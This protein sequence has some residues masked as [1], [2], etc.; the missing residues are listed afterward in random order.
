MLPLHSRGLKGL[1]TTKAGAGKFQ[2]C[3]RGRTSETK[4][5]LSHRDTLSRNCNIV[6][7]GSADLRFV[8]V[9]ME[10]FVYKADG[11]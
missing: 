6:G 1:G 8:D 7:L 11:R 5:D 9:W 2:K 10:N 4:F 3:S